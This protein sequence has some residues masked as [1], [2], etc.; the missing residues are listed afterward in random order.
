MIVSI[1]PGRL[2]F[3]NVSITYLISNM[4]ASIGFLRYS[5]GRYS[6]PDQVPPRWTLISLHLAFQYRFCFTYLDLITF[7]FQILSVAVSYVCS[8]FLHW[9]IQWCFSW[10]IIIVRMD[11]YI[12]KLFFIILYNFVCVLNKHTCEYIVVLNIECDI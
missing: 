11:I 6:L 4:H 5:L 10:V 2:F 12:H 7:L 9:N 8:L 3:W 1:R